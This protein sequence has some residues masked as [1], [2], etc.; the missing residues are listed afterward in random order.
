MLKGFNVSAVSSDVASDLFFPEILSGLWPF[1]QI[2]LM[3]MP[4]TAV[5]KDCCFVFGKH[6]VGPS[7]QA[8]VMKAI[9]ISPAEQ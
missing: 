6:Q 5:N 7:R 9:P 8:A 3:A 1:K 2:A 4:E